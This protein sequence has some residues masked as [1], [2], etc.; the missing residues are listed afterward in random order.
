MYVLV[1]DSLVVVPTI[2]IIIYSQYFEK[3]TCILFD[4]INYYER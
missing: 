1:G 3:N 2:E 4:N